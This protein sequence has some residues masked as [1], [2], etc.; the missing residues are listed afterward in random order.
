VTFVN[1][2]SSL[3]SITEG[4]HSAPGRPGALVVVERRFSPV[5]TGPGPTFDA[6]QTLRHSWPAPAR[7]GRHSRPRLTLFLGDAVLGAANAALHVHDLPEH[8]G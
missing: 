1:G 2:C 6:R 7:R 5:R 3:N 8:N 4:N